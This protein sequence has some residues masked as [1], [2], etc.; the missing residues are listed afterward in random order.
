MAQQSQNILRSSV[1]SKKPLIITMII[2]FFLFFSIISIGIYAI[3]NYQYEKNILLSEMRIEDFLMAIS[4][5]SSWNFTLPF[6]FEIVKD[7][8]SQQLSLWWLYLSIIVLVFIYMT[9]RTKNEFK[10][11][12]HGSAKW[13]DTYVIKSYNNPE[14]G[15]PI[16]K[17]LYVPKNG[18]KTANLNEIVI[19]GS[20]GGKTFRK[21]K[22]DILQMNGSYVVTDPKGELYRDCAKMLKN[23]GY[24]VK[25]LNLKDI[26]FSNSYNPFVYLT[27]EQDVVS[28]ADLFMK[29]TKGEGE[30]DDFWSGSALEVLTMLMT[31]LFKAKDEIKSFGR[32]VRI[33]NSLRYENG[34]IDMSCE[35]ARCMNRHV[36]LYP[37]DVATVSWNGM[38]GLAQETMSSILKVLSTRLSLFSTTDL[39]AITSTDEMDFDNLGVEL[40]VIFLIIPAA[41]NTYKAVCNIFYSQLFE[42]LMRVADNKYDGCLPLLVS[43]ELDEFANIGEIPAFNETLAVVRSYNIRICIVLQGLSQLSALYEKTYESIIGNCDIFTMLGSKDND[44][45]KYVSDKLGKITVRGDSRSYSRGGMQSGGQDTEA[46]IERP[47]LY[48]EEV[49]KVCKPTGRNKKYGGACILFIGYE[50]PICVPKFDTINHPLFSECGSKFKEYVHN[51]TYV[52]K[53]YSE[54]FNERMKRYKTMYDD[55]FEREAADKA[56]YEDKIKLEQEDEQMELENEFNKYNQQAD[57]NISL[58]DTFEPTEEEYALYASEVDDEN[59]ESVADFDDDYDENLIFDDIAP[60]VADIQTQ[61]QGV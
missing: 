58:P 43:C 23:K 14:N 12:E 59:Y 6:S 53:E 15:I 37:N 41:R 16:A 38:Q 10:G 35:F 27:S 8:L 48:P 45:L 26:N 49:K 25:V 44:T 17:D 24:R 2:L 11:M 51:N 54:I 46:Y 9:T 20:G 40:T 18:S 32:I 56:V 4:A 42:R 60:I 34:H 55:Y 28:L 31:Y 30:K 50:D 29:N 36:I 7:I 52:E 22:P 47:L 57:N 61:G 33:V 1:K 3:L 19:A 21:I 5:I 13:A 39:D